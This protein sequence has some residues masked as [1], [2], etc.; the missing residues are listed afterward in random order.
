[1]TITCLGWSCFYDEFI[2]DPMETTLI[3]RKWSVFL[4]TDMETRFCLQ[5]TVLVHGAETELTDVGL[6]PLEGAFHASCCRISY[7]QLTAV[8]LPGRAEGNRSI[9]DYIYVKH[10]TSKLTF[11]RK[12]AILVSTPSKLHMEKAYMPVNFIVLSVLLCL[13]DTVI[14]LWNIINHFWEALKCLHV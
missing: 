5:V 2:L 14:V 8:C 11:A 12:S 4:V 13:I 7:Y 9:C 10:T 3:I 6:F 1:M